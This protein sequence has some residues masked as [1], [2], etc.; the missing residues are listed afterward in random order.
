MLQAILDFILY[1]PR[2]IYFH[3]EDY[4][5]LKSENRQSEIIIT[6]QQRLFKRIIEVCESNTYGS[7]ELKIRKIKELAQTSP[8]E[9]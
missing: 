1:I 9:N 4:N 2:R 6:N 3:F 7:Y 5:N 8:N